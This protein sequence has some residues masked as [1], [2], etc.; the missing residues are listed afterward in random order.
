MRE[1]AEATDLCLRE[2]QIRHL[3][4]LELNSCEREPPFGWA[5]QCLAE[6][7]MSPT[8]WRFAFTRI[9]LEYIEMPDLKLTEAQVRRLCNLP[10]DVCAAA[11]AALLQAGF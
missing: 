1:V 7:L 4:V 9:Q 8:E 10:H 6:A 3:D 5:H 2:L 11:L